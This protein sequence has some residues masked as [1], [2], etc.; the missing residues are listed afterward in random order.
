MLL[1]LALPVRPVRGEYSL[2]YKFQSW[3]EDNGR[4]RVD[5]H[6]AEV[7][8]T[9]STETKL[10]LVGLI[11][12][13]AGATPSGQPAR[14]GSDQVPLSTLTDRREAWH[15]DITH[16]FNRVTVT[17]GFATSKDAALVVTLPPGGYTAVV[18]GADGGAGVVLVEA[19][20]LDL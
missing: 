6:Y 17:G 4:V 14:P 15:L 9:L 12:T 7:S 18:S 20:D 19:Y 11:D 1:W 16:P 8:T 10:K 2:S 5:A 13:I 3:Q